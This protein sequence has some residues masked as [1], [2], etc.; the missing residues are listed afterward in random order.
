[1]AFVGFSQSLRSISSEI[2]PAQIQI[3]RDVY[4]VPHIF[5][6][7]D[8]EVAYG[9]A[10]AHAEDDFATLQ[11]TF[12]ASKA[13]L[14]E[15]IGRDGATID[16]IVHLLRLRELVEQKYDS[17]IS[18]AFKSLLQGYCDGVNAYARTNP[19]EILERKAFP[20]SPHDILIYSVLQMA[21]GCGVEDALKDIY[22]GKIS[23][24][25]FQV[26]GSNAFAFN[27]K[28][29]TDGNVYLAINT[30][31]P[32]E[33]QISWYEAHL[34]S[35]EGLNI[36]GALFP[37]A[38]VIFTGVNENLGWTH[39]VNYPD[40]LDVFQ[41][42]MNRDNS[43]QYKVDDKWHTLEETTVSLKV[44]VPGF[45]IPVKRKAYWSIYGPTIITTRGVFAIRS[46]GLMDIRGLEQWYRMGKSRNFSEFRKALGM[47]AVPG[48]NVM[49]GDR[50]DTIYYLSNGRL[51]VRKPGY[52]WKQ[53][54]PG[55]T[56]ETLWT[57]FHP[58]A[59]LPQVLNPSS[60]YLFN[61]NHSPFNATAA[62]DNIKS[63]DY[64]ATMGYEERVNN[65]SL[66]VTEMLAE[67]PRVSYDDFKKIKY[68]LY[69]PQ[70][71]SYPVNIDTLFRLDEK[72]YPDVADLIGILKKWDRQANIE[73]NG[74]AIFA[75]AFYQIAEK[76]QADKT[77]TVCGEKLSV[78][79]LRNTKAY[80]LKNFRTTEVTLGQY[81]RLER[82]D[83]S[84]PLPG[85]PD[86]L[87]TMYSKPSKNGRVKAVLGECYIALIKF[88]P[89]G[90]EIE[91]INAYGASNRADS[92][93]YSDQMEMF[94]QQQTKK[95]TL[96]RDQVFLDAE[97]IYSP[98]VHPKLLATR[99]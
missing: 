50:Y 30:H 54:V 81:Q 9:L 34:S 92:P 83:K 58:L 95:M 80:L 18:P 10:W 55:N 39:T 6:E 28:K 4:G 73:S 69:L 17:D 98:E 89:A 65:R 13:M 24:A 36:I 82:G 60:G 19:K 64:D 5:A 45:N 41:L 86:V 77:F 20:V 71:L 70:Q 97:D 91:T 33:G 79:V 38:P 15:Y 22:K 84:L 40:R 90:P 72:I 47:E 63:K 78:E 29:T 76:Y 48:Y 85:L 37:G 74:A 46:A 16:Y 96:D 52:D 87:A 56:T 99:R 57:S 61:V 14:G 49:Y 75:V 42:E 62:R 26:A 43:L 59:K 27:S 32:L 88:T 35:N 93:H 12:L 31:H 8:A 2:D 23:L 68:D 66:R 7:T 21:I 44:N 53:T 67:M 25:D 3:A 94:Q 1:M 11:K 51:P